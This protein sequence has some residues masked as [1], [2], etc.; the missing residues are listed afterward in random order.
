[1]TA[2]QSFWTWLIAEVTEVDLYS[3]ERFVKQKASKQGADFCSA[4]D[5]PKL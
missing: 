4:A 3:I 5:L 1:M 2:F